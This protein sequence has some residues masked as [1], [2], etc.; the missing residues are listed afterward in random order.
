MCLLNYKPSL[1]K[2]VCPYANES[3][4]VLRNSRDQIAGR[5]ALCACEVDGAHGAYVQSSTI[6]SQRARKADAQH[7]SVSW[8]IRFERRL[9]PAWYFTSWERVAVRQAAEYMIQANATP[10]PEQQGGHSQNNPDRR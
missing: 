8:R 10:H 1:N 5:V 9:D 3:R 4:A 7:T 6:S 2:K